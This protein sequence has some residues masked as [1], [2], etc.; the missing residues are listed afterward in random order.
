MQ[1]PQIDAGTWVTLNRLLDEALE[2]PAAQLPQWLDDLSPEFDGLK[3]RL[4]EIL[5]RSGLIETGEFMHTLPKLEL[6]PGDLAGAP[7]RA[8]QPGREIGPY[9][10]VRELGSGGMGVVWLAERTDGLINRPVA[11]KL[12]HG[13]WK[14][15]GLAE[16]MARER[17]ILASLTHPHIAHLYD[18]GL[19][20]DGQPYLAIEYVEGCRIDV[21]CHEQQL[22]LRARLEL[23]RQVGNAVAYAHHKL[24]VHRDLKPANILVGADGQARLLD[25][26]I[27][28]LLDD[29]QAKETRFTEV[30]GRALTP[31]YASPEQILGEP[32]TT[33]SDVYSLGVILYELLSGHRPYKLQ[34]D[35]RGALEDA[36]VQAES[37]APST[38][39]D[40]PWRHAL[41]GDLDTV[42]LKALKK[43][44][45]DR[46]PTVHALLDDIER[47]LGDRPVLAQ[48]DSRWYRTRKFIRRNLIALGTSSAVLLAVLG[49]AGAAAWQARLAVAQQKRAEVVKEFV[50]SI[51]REASPYSGTG[52]TSLSAVDLLKQAERKLGSGFAEQPRVRIELLALI[53]ESLLALGDLDAAEPMLDR[54]ATEARQTMDER[55][56]MAVRVSLLQA[57]VHLMRGRAR[58]A[59][60]EFDR[61][62]PLMRSDP[63][64]DPLDL[65]GALGNRTMLAIE[66]VAYEDA[67]RFA[68]EGA[69]LA[70]ARLGNNHDQ[71][72]TSSI[73]LALAYR[74]SKKF[75]QSRD[76]AKDA[77]VAAVA[78]FGATPPHARVIE[79]KTTYGRALADTGDLPAGIA[80][81]DSA[82]VDIRALTGAESFALGTTLQNLVAYRIDHGELSLADSNATEALNILGAQ[83]QTESVTYAATLSAR[84]QVR[85]ARRDA[86][87]A[88]DDLERVVP[89]LERLLGGEREMTL[90]A[91]SCKALALAYL[92]RL[93]DAQDE[94]ETAA[95]IAN[96]KMD[97]DVVAA[98]IAQVRGTIARLR[99]DPQSALQWQQAV[100]T[101]K[102]ARPKLQRER[103]RALAEIGLVHL[104]MDETTPAAAALEQSLEEFERL[105]SRV[106][107]ARADAL[108]GLG[109]ARLA[110]GRAADALPPLEIAHGF[111]REFAP[112]SRW[113]GEAA[114]WLGQCY[115]ALG[116]N[117]EA[118]EALGRARIL[119]AEFPDS[120]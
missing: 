1:K 3:P 81:I 60:A 65:A 44:P 20:A 90:L 78:H 5:S 91:R 4:R 35:S 59:R 105:E 95:E 29:G 55:D 76:A 38:V 41:R 57:Q 26:G 25:F 118:R 52:T 48:P 108:V 73:L 15:T 119:L 66:E 109:R 104:D 19:T 56:A 96:G 13:A 37:S 11:L 115:L 72:V 31:D 99:G 89:I 112:A 43:K 49:G 82:V 32:L 54:A 51:F 101:S 106:T 40:R 98:R 77:Y 116:R 107:P 23:F 8:E 39:A 33:A 87:A 84:A 58:Q 17:E 83:V 30:S 111:W 79:A 114:L 110:Q 7:V 64:I 2:Q 74:Y 36:I 53:G 69:R 75:G 100:S 9:R 85:L 24:V 63:K 47:Y 97:L 14:R 62:L 113:A 70:T 92:G 45:A 94:I 86:A 71:T 12:P 22:S 27:A 120:R 102:D 21:Y 46:Y 80:L 67:E 68:L 10:L 50:A 6:D 117:A 16:R 42:V 61:I 34:R 28:K 103:M 18:A 93:G 88:L